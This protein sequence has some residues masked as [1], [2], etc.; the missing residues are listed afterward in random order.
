MNRE[1]VI[2][3]GEKAFDPQK[4]PNEAWKKL[5]GGPEWTSEWSAFYEGWCNSQK[6]H[7]AKRRKELK[8]NEFFAE[9]EELKKKH[10]VTLWYGGGDA[11]CGFKFEEYEAGL[12]GEEYGI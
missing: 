2:K 6:I 9:L 4:H 11:D 10:N 5:K 1:E 8:V 12:N 3:T 7:M